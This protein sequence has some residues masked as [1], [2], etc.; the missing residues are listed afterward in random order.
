[1]FESVEKLFDILGINLTYSLDDELSAAP[2]DVPMVGFIA[3]GG[4]EDKEDTTRAYVNNGDN[5]HEDVP[6]PPMLVRAGDFFCLEIRGSS[7]RPA[8]NDGD[9]LFFR[10]DD[11]L[12]SQPEKLLGHYCAVRLE[13]DEQYIKR[14][15]RPDSGKR[16]EWNLESLNPVWP[17]MTNQKVIEA[18][19]VRYTMHKI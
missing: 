16:L 19:P 5:G 18:L 11:P 2:V 7:M 15:A 6:G 12:R 14:L 8:F 17:V 9:R 1:M 13:N 10:G 4:G 3:A